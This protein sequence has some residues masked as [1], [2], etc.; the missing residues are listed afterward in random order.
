MYR[1]A[2]ENKDGEKYEFECDG[3][4]N[5]Y[6]FTE[7]LGIKGYPYGLKIGENRNGVKVLLKADNDFDESIA[8]ILRENRNTLNDALIVSRALGEVQDEWMREEIERNALNGQYATKEELY[9]DIRKMKIELSSWQED[10]YCPL[11]AVIIETVDKNSREQQTRE[12]TKR[13]SR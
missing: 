13:L 11:H 3:T 12:S 5:L 10:F 1:I 8:K 2:I 9:A 7:E 4:A 6:A